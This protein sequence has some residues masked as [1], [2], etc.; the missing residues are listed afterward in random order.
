MSEDK[1]NISGEIPQKSIDVDKVKEEWRQ[2]PEADR[3]E[4]VKQY[5]ADR[6]D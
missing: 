2:I 4:A 3:V 6:K 5:L 1:G